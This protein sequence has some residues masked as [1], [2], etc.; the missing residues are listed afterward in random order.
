RPQVLADQHAHDEASDEA[1]E[2]GAASKDGHCGHR[3]AAVYFVVT[4]ESLLLGIVAAPSARAAM[5]LLSS[6]CCCEARKI[7]VRVKSLKKASSSRPDGAPS[8]SPRRA[9]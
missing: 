5:H 6:R 1:H 3:D 7:V 9:C 2:G 4:H 8:T